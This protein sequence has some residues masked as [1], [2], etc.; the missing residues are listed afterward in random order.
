[1]RRLGLLL[2]LAAACLACAG[3]A[4]AKVRIVG[5]DTVPLMSGNVSPLLTLP[6]G[7]PIGVRFRDH[8]MF[9]TGTEGLTVYD[10]AKPEMP[11]PV[12][13]LPLPHFENEDVDLGGNT[14]LISN[15]PSESAGV[16][17]VI[18]I[19]NPAMPTLKGAMV[20]GYNDGQIEDS[21]NLLTGE[22]GVDP[23]SSGLPLG[24][25]HTA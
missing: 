18:D 9:V 22:F 17:Y 16:L 4:A 1:M 12:G 19:S 5:D 20:N 11:T 6:V 3:P 2:T 15:D 21:V 10:I 8:Y 14:L 7:K 25:G 24:I 13:A 23:V